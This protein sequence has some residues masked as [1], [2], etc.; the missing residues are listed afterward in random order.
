M[1]FDIRH[2]SKFLIAAERLSS[3]IT[4]FTR[5]GMLIPHDEKIWGADGGRPGE[6][7]TEMYS[8]ESPFGREAIH[9]S[10]GSHRNLLEHRRFQNSL[11]RRILTIANAKRW[12]DNAYN[13][14]GQFRECIA[15]I[16][17]TLAD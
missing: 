13:W 14:D 6:S 4:S 15:L 7:N 2:A 11:I 17:S 9:H 10:E 12:E 3:A 5:Y 8:T 1:I 16:E